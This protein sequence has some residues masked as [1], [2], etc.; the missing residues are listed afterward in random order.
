LAV[1]ILP[2]TP[3]RVEE[4]LLLM[5]ALFETGQ[6]ASAQQHAERFWRSSSQARAIENRYPDGPGP[7]DEPPA[8]AAVVTLYERFKVNPTEVRA[9]RK[10]AET[11]F[12]LPEAERDL[13]VLRDLAS[14]FPREP[15]ILWMIVRTEWD[16]GSYTNAAQWAVRLANVVSQMR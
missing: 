2:K 5:R 14:R 4:R 7:T 13:D 10:I 11:L 9:A 3:V 1:N 15:R 16:R 12:A 8:K 6:Y